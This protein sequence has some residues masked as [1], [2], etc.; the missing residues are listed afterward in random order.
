MQA[1]PGSWHPHPVDE[2]T[3][4]DGVARVLIVRKSEG[5]IGRRVTI[6]EWPF[7][8]GRGSSAN[9]DLDAEK[10]SRAHARIFWQA[11]K[12]WLE[13]LGSSNGTMINGEMLEAPHALS[14]EDVIQ[15]AD[16]ELEYQEILL[17]AKPTDSTETVVM[18]L[19]D[20]EA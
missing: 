5:S 19:D 8:I 6:D 7:V 20:D 1:D 11:G 9:L 15:I 2:R 3:D 17:S 13:D 14:V 12:A 16:L 10:A 4:V 18:P